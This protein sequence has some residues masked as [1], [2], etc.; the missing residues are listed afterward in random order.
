M[1]RRQTRRLQSAVALTAVLSLAACSQDGPLAPEFESARAS[2]TVEAVPGFSVMTWNLYVGARLE[3]LLVITDPS[4]IPF[5]VTKLVGEV[6]ATDFPARAEAIVDQIER[7]NP[8][9]VS[10]QEMSEFRMQSPGDFLVGNPVPATDPFMDWRV[11]LD[12]ALT[13]RGLSYSVVAQAMNFDIELPMVDF[14][15]GGLDDVRLTDYD[16]ILVRDDVRWKSAASGNFEAVLPLDLGG[17]TIPKPSGWAAV[18][19]RLDQR[20]YRVFNTH[21]EPADLPGGGVNPQLAALHAAQYAELSAIMHRSRNP[22]ILTGDINS[23]ADGSST[24]TY[25]QLL[26]EGFIDLWVAGAGAG[27]GYTSNQEADL[28]NPVSQLFHRIDFILFR[29]PSAKKTGVLP[30]PAAAEV[31][32]DEPADRTPGGLW[33]SDHAGVVTSMTLFNRG[34]R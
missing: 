32:G 22:Q 7:T 20:W 5:E 23:A 21:L 29:H 16:V 11:I 13:N 25:Q 17:F 19:V 26:Q 1:N 33:P 9:V 34:N 3:N 6:M 2:N 28:K 8:A 14:S 27:S 4:T 31:V 10:L 24:P 12:N 15:T 18:D 30:G